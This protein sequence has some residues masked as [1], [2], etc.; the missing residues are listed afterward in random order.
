MPG[1]MSGPFYISASNTFPT[2]GGRPVLISEHEFRE[3]C[4][5]TGCFC[6]TIYE[7]DCD[8]NAW[9]LA[10]SGKSDF[11][12]TFFLTPPPYDQWNYFYFKRTIPRSATIIRATYGEWID[13]ADS[14]PT[15]AAPSAPLAVWR[16]WKCDGSEPTEPTA[17]GDCQ[18]LA[19][20]EYDCLTSEWILVRVDV[21]RARLPAN[22]EIVNPTDNRFV[23]IFGRVFSC[24]DDEEDAPDDPGPPKTVSIDDINCFPT[25]CPCTVAN[26]GAW[27]CGGLLQTYTISQWE[28]ELPAGG[29]FAVGQRILRLK[30]GHTVTDRVSDTCAWVNAAQAPV[31][32]S[33]D[34][35]ATWADVNNYFMT[36][37]LDTTQ[38]WEVLVQLPSLDFISVFK[39][40]DQDPI[41]SYAENVEYNGTPSSRVVTATVT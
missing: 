18:K 8:A 10:A 35:G 17:T 40:S 21:I 12:D 31:E 41:G 16:A 11:V 39:T 2:Q 5:G 33:D 34:F 15:P 4:C 24:T 3:C 1:L 36:V 30:S 29:G 19:Y 6:Y 38:G 26:P 22:T 28:Y 23:Q 25:T 13:C 14:C 7:W 32:Y 37:Q 9:V 20:Y 27:P